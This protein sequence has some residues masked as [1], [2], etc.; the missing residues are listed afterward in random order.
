MPIYNTPNQIHSYKYYKLEWKLF[1]ISVLPKNVGL[2]LIQLKDNL[3]W[4]YRPY[5]ILCIQIFPSKVQGYVYYHKYRL[6]TQ[7]AFKDH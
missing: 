4:M 7:C 3:Y 6:M 1:D 5:N 2:R